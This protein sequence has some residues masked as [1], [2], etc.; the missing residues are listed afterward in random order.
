MDTG[1][2]IS[3]GARI[4]LWEGEEAFRAFL[5]EIRDK[6]PIAHRLL[7]AW[8][9][10]LQHR[11]LE[12]IRKAAKLVPEL[13][14]QPVFLERALKILGLAHKDMGDVEVAENYFLKEKDIL[15]RVLGKDTKDVDINLILLYMSKAEFKRI[16]EEVPKLLE[17]E[18]DET[19]R[20]HLRFALA[21]AHL[22]QG[23]PERA[24]RLTKELAEESHKV[25]FYNA[26]GIWELLG[27]VER[28]LGNFER[29]EEA[30]LRGLEIA[31]ERKVSYA[32]FICAKLGEMGKLPERAVVQKCVRL[33]KRGGKGEAAAIREIQA[34]LEDEPA[35]RALGFYEAG[36]GYFEAWQPYEG[37]YTTLLGLREAKEA[38]VDEG[39]WEALERVRAYAGVFRNMRDDPIVGEMFRAVEPLAKMG[40]GE[41]GVLL[42]AQLIGGLRLWVKGREVEPKRWRNQK[43]LKLLVYLLLA[44]QHRLPRDYLAYL[45]W[46]KE[47]YSERVRNR[48]RVAA[49]YIRKA[50]GV[51]EVIVRSG[52]SYEL[53]GV[54]SDLDELRELTKGNSLGQKEARRL[55]ELL[56]GELLPEFKYDRYVDEYRRYHEALRE[57]FRGSPAR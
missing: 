28:Q 7:E 29:A 16:L 55:A 9:L 46:P 18:T 21:L 47:R 42:K 19:A 33:G 26:L 38:K 20:M 52:G 57:R 4:F 35:E 15:G 5:R 30:F 12:A 13:S 31:I 37:F 2:L 1:K 17:G 45:L 11:P 48:L 6:D 10:V 54:K 40:K 24:L 34:L 23:D 43:A 14:D 39:F 32:P 51:P 50:L 36:K 25:D 56:E 44:P 22:T 27:I 53:R 3:R 41:E 49:S 8:S